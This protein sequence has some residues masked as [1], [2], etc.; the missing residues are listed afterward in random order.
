MK[1]HILCTTTQPFFLSQEKVNG[2]LLAM[3]QI[4]C[5]L[6]YI[7]KLKRVLTSK[8]FSEVLMLKLRRLKLL[9]KFDEV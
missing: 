4:G 8:E 1:V 6:D 7:L 2:T 3:F 5:T 9:K